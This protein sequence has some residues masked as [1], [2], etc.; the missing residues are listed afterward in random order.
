MLFKV[1]SKKLLALIIVPT[2]FLS[3]CVKEIDEYVAPSPSSAPVKDMS[4]LQ[5]PANFD[6]TLDKDFQLNITMK[7]NDD[8]P[9]PGVIVKI[10][11]AVIY[12]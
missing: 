2:L 12:V 11:D 6:Y 9:L 7:G 8:V 4:E 3:S 5:V 10:V 1:N